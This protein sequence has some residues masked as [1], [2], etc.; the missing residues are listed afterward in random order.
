MTLSELTQVAY[1]FHPRGLHPASLGYNGTEEHERQR[2]AVRAARSE[3]PKWAAMLER[4]GARFSLE[5]R[6]MYLSSDD[7]FDSAYLATVFF[8]SE[9]QEHGLG[10]HVSILGPYYVVHRLG[11][12]GEEPCAQAVAREIEATYPGYEPIPPELGDAIVPDVLVCGQGLGM[13]TIYDCLL[14]GRHPG[15]SRSPP[16]RSEPPVEGSPAAPVRKGPGTFRF[17]LIPGKPKR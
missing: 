8:T 16:P 14:G 13:V 12:P 9:G 11:L 5:N 4:L 3:Y 6:S 1:W 17:Q 2:A 7:F 10:L 15:E